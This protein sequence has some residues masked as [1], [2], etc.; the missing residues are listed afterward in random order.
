MK[1][2]ILL[3]VMLCGCASASPIDLITPTIVPPLA[4]QLGYNIPDVKGVTTV[5]IVKGFLEVEKL[6]LQTLDASAHMTLKATQTAVDGLLGVL[7]TL[8]LVGTGVG[9]PVALRRLPKGAVSKGDYEKA[10]KMS[11]EEFNSKES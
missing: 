7:A 6:K 2:A 4:E 8:G 9:V 10:G 5:G 3:V 1:Y 11:P